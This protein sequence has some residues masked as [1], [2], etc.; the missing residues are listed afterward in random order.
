MGRLVEKKGYDDLLNALARLPDDLDW[1]FEHIGGGDLERVMTAR[2]REL[3]LTDQIFWHGRKPQSDVKDLLANADIFVLASKIATD[4]DRDGLPNVLM[5]AQAVGVACISTAVS[6]IPELIRD[7][8]TG[9]LVPPGDPDALAATIARLATDT[10]L[11]K[12]LAAAGA[13]R[14]R[15]TFDLDAGIDAISDALRTDSVPHTKAA[16]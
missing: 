6:A 3:G 4:G 8:D 13:E 5:E 10:E 15:T 12:R 11:R 7:G 1:R 2:A 9:L 16:A 14:V